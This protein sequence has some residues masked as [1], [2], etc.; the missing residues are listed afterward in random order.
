MIILKDTSE[1]LLKQRYLDIYNKYSDNIYYNDSP[2][3][4]TE[5]AIVVEDFPD[6]FVKKI[7]E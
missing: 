6:S 5:L 3:L 2:K 7:N 4:F 1:K